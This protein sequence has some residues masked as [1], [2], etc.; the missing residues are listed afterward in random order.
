MEV[1]Y[2]VQSEYSEKQMQY[3]RKT[4]PYR[5]W[6]QILKWFCYVIGG[7]SVFVNLIV[8]IAAPLNK[9]SIFNI[10]TFLIGVFL[11]VD[12]AMNSHFLD[13]IYEKRVK[14]TKRD[15]AITLSFYEQ[16]I[17]IQFEKDNRQET[18]PYSAITRVGKDFEG[19]FLKAQK[20]LFYVKRKQFDIGDGYEF[21]KFLKE[22]TGLEIK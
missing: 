10:I 5:I 20:E 6:F 11:L 3:Y 4:K 9:I 15:G 16:E 12:G 8:F 1:I 18:I 19:Y 22:K 2:Q 7:I 14:K 21:P 17:K 13:I